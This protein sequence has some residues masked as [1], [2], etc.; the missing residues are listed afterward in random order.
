MGCP[1]SS[2]TKPVVSYMPKSTEHVKGREALARRH[3]FREPGIDASE[4]GEGAVGL[5]GGREV[6]DASVDGADVAVCGISTASA[7]LAP[8]I[9]HRRPLAFVRPFF[10]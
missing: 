2:I 4:G 1:A 9:T 5:L 10:T 6:S 3:P 7:W 8:W